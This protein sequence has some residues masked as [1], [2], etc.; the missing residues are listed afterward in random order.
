MTRLKMSVTLP[1]NISNFELSA[2][3]VNECK[4]FEATWLSDT[5]AVFS[6]NDTKT[7]LKKIFEKHDIIVNDISCEYILHSS[8]TKL[9]N[10]EFVTTVAPHTVITSLD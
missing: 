8:T 5:K 1:E 2:N 4:N 9:I 10:D 7:Q 3:L 6:T